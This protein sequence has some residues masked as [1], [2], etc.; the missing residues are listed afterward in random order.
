MR[1]K[2]LMP[3]QREDLGCV[4]VYIS[5]V[6]IGSTPVI[7]NSEPNFRKGPE[8]EIQSETLPTLSSLFAQ[9]R[10]INFSLSAFAR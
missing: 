3:H 9:E 8:A 1:E 6:R 7:E 10:L 5:W 4:R 2:I